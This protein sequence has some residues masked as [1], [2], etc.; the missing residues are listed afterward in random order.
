MT[1]RT[2]DYSRPREQDWIDA[3]IHALELESLE[4]LEQLA[5]VEVGYGYR[6]WNWLSASAMAD[7]SQNAVALYMKWRFPDCYAFA[8]FDHEGQFGGQGLAAGLAELIEIGCDGLKMIEN[9]P[10]ERIRLGLSVL[11]P[12]I[13]EALSWLESAGVPAL[14]HVGDP[15]PFWDPERVPDW[16]RANGWFYGEGDYVGLDELYA[17]HETM[18]ARHPQLQVIFAH[19]FF[20]SDAPQ[21]LADCFERFPNMHVDLC[22][23][24]EM[25]VD[26]ARDPA[27][28]RDFMA[29]WRTRLIYGTDNTPPSG[30]ADQFSADMINTMQQGMLLDTAPVPFWD[31]QLAGLGLDAETLRALTRENFLRLVGGPPRPLDRERAIDWL[32][33]FIA[34]GRSP[35]LE[36]VRAM[37]DAM[38]GDRD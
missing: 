5:A 33:R 32:E 22:S 24:S 23:G 20:M 34:E 12:G 36:V 10:T 30:R 27:F 2:E 8:G 17:E 9:K 37:R 14:M 1:T 19:F 7:A 21:R 26:F 11:D 13:D 25:Y 31:Q 16:A 6:R 38:A 18:L 4:Q 15:A 29:R 28:W 3:H 35:R